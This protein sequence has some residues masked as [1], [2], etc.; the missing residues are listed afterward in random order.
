MPIQT[1]TTKATLQVTLNVV[2]GGGGASPPGVFEPHV[3]MTWDPSLLTLVTV[4]SPQPTFTCAGCI[5]WAAHPVPTG[6]IGKDFIASFSCNGNAD[7]DVTGAAL[8][9]DTTPPQT[10]ASKVKL[11]CP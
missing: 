8:R 3:T 7:A 4:Q 11:P 9:S 5:T 1:M 2:D 6:E 10:H